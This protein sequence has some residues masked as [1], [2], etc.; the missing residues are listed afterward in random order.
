MRR[1]CNYSISIFLCFLSSQPSSDLL[2]GI[3]CEMVET[4]KGDEVGRLCVVDKAM[5]IKLD[6][7]VRPGAPIV[8][9][10]TAVS[11]LSADNLESATL[12][13]ADVHTLLRST[14]PK[15]AILVG[16]SL[17]NDLKALHLVHLRCIDTSILYPHPIPHL[18]FSLRRLAQKI[19]LKDLKRHH[20]VHDPKED[21]EAALRLAVKKI[22]NGHSFGMPLRRRTPLAEVLCERSKTES[23]AS[24]VHLIDSFSHGEARMLQVRCNKMLRMQCHRAVLSGLVLH[25]RHGET[26]EVPN[27]WML[28]AICVLGCRSIR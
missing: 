24:V 7:F 16:H 12:C 13:L 4:T 28:L 2:F 23:T 10:R 9:Y 3:D 27:V 15:G 5:R 1:G 20:G 17:E 8:D 22:K 14:L 21:A 6:V 11:G 25:R 18:R 26:S 19:L